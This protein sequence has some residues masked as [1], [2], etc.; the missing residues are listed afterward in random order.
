MFKLIVPSAIT[1]A[2]TSTAVESPYATWAAGT[3]YA[4]GDI[5]PGIPVIL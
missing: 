2:A 4:K 3:T 5:R 1:A